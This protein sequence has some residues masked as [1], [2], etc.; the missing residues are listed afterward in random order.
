MEIYHAVSKR[1]LFEFVVSI[2]V[3]T[4]AADCC[5]INKPQETQQMDSKMS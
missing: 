4:S 5:L 2:F 3:K 1:M